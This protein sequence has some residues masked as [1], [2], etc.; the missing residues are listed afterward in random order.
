MYGF[1]FFKSYHEAAKH[2]SDEDQGIFYKAI[3][4][5][6]FDD[7]TPTFEGHLMGFWMLVEPNL[8]TSKL[9]SKAGKTESKQ[10]QK[11][12]KPES[13][14]E[15][16][17]PKEKEKE[18]ERDKEINIGVFT[19]EQF[20]LIRAYR[21][22]MRKPLKTQQAVTGLSRD[23][24]ECMKAGYSFE[25]LFELM[26]EK[27]WQSI[28]LEWVAKEIKPAKQPQGGRRIGGYEIG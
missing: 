26:Q 23:F 7:V 5:Y 4:D 25:K 2:L 14:P 24:G 18:K 16:S 10:N 28:K 1:T 12:I 19:P 13:K 17:P 27:Q 20:E 15:L 8:K 9:R 22:K 3:L 11:E 21:S 6:M